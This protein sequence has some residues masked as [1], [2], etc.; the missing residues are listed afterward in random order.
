MKFFNEISMEQ[1][2]FFAGFARN[3]PPDKCFARIAFHFIPLVSFNYYLP[4]LK[5]ATLPSISLPTAL[6]LSSN[7]KG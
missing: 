3:E 6:Q 4:V 7:R 1:Y 5:E 2:V